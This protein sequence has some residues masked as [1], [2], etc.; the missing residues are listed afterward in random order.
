[1]AA[2]VFLSFPDTDNNNDLEKFLFP[3]MERG[4][5]KFQNI[6]Q[7]RFPPDYDPEILLKTMQEDADETLLHIHIVYDS[8][9]IFKDGYMPIKLNEKSIEVFPR[10]SLN[11]LKN[12]IFKKK[13]EI[14]QQSKIQKTIWKT[15]GLGEKD[16]TYMANQFVKDSYS[17]IDR[18]TG[19]LLNATEIP[20]YPS[21]AVKNM[22]ADEIKRCEP[23][24]RESI[25]K[26]FL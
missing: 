18:M 2:P 26:S 21:H 7:I 3:S 10:D 17:D 8:S 24:I 5:I 20:I 15:M 16:A 6:N 19:D 11:N 23:T 9:I 25:E 13:M 1:M 14:L 22:I 4:Y 12:K